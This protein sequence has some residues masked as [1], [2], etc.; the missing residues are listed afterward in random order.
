MRLFS[1]KSFNIAKATWFCINSIIKLMYDSYVKAGANEIQYL[2]HTKKI[3]MN[4][5]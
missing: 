5:R 1:H 2:T 4:F 3:I